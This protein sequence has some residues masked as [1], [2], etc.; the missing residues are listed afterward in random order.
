MLELAIGEYYEGFL[1]SSDK[2]IKMT[3]QIINTV[4]GRKHKIKINR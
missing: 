4:I 3:W 1:T 2:Y